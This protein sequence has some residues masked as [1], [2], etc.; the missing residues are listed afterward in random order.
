MTAQPRPLTAADV[1]IYTVTAPHLAGAIGVQ[2]FQDR[3]TAAQSVV[4][5]MLGWRMRRVRQFCERHGWIL[6]WEYPPIF[7]EGKNT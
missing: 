2:Q 7:S 4:A 6:R 5:F 3:V 1:L